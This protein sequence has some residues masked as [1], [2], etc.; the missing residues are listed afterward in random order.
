MGAAYTRLLDKRPLPTKMLTAAAMFCISDAIAQAAES[1]EARGKS[2]QHQ[3]SISLKRLVKFCVCGLFQGAV[4]HHLYNWTDNIFVRLYIDRVFQTKAASVVATVAFDQLIWTPFWYIAY[5]FPLL[6]ILDGALFKGVHVWLNYIRAGI[7]GALSPVWMKNM[8]CWGPCNLILYGFVPTALKPITQ[9]AISLLWGIILSMSTMKCSGMEPT[10]KHINS[11][12]HELSETAA[13]ISTG[14]QEA[15]S[16]CSTPTTR[17]GTQPCSCLASSDM[18]VECRLSCPANRFCCND[19]SPNARVQNVGCR[20]T[21]DDATQC[22]ENN[23]TPDTCMHG[24]MLSQ[25][26]E[27]IATP[28]S[29]P[30][31]A[32]VI[33]GTT[34]PP[35]SPLAKL[36]C[37]NAILFPAIVITTLLRTRS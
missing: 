26:K 2:N 12:M 11:S 34:F 10:P 23:I 22:E 3:V 7:V 27:S 31:S 9:N 14:E 4:G 35:F 17:P 37:I 36:G 24:C 25:P 28:P 15:D 21:F 30:C 8:L 5:F 20:I 33:G 6:G 13:R 32:A 1:N 29:K 16:P 18:H 19:T